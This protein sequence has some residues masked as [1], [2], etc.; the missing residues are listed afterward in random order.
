MKS[1]A[2][3]VLNG[4]DSGHCLWV[5]LEQVARVGSREP[6]DYVI[7]ADADGADFLFQIGHAR[8]GCFAENL[9]SQSPIAVNEKPL[10]RCRLQD[11]DILIA[12][13]VRFRAMIE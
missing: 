3:Q 1:V 6:A 11:G 5:R 12:G 8:A 13:T 10:D 9:D 2:L 7:G 4:P